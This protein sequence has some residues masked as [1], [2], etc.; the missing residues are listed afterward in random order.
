MSN[1]LPPLAVPMPRKRKPSTASNFSLPPLSSWCGGERALSS[2]SS[3]PPRSSSPPITP[4]SSRGN[5]L[6]YIRSSPAFGSEIGHHAASDL[7]DEFPSTW[8]RHHIHAVAKQP[9]APIFLP[10]FK[11]LFCDPAPETQST[12][13]RGPP[14]PSEHS[15]F[16]SEQRRSASSQPA[17][18]APVF[19]VSEE[20]D[21]EDDS[22]GYSFVQEDV[23][24][25]FFRVSAERGQWK[26]DPLPL[27]TSTRSLLRQSA[28]TSTPP[29]ISGLQLLARPISEPA[30]ST[31]RASTPPTTPDSHEEEDHGSE[32]PSMDY[33]D[34]MSSDHCSPL[35]YNSSR[36]LPSL[37][38]DAASTELDDHAVPSSPLPPSSPPLS[39]LPASPLMRSISPLSFAPSS[40]HLQPS[41]PLSFVESLSP[42]DDQDMDLQNDDEADTVPTP[43]PQ[44]TPSLEN[45]APTSPEVGLPARSTDSP[46][47]TLRPQIVPVP[48]CEATTQDSQAQSTQS[49]SPVLEDAVLAEES[50]PSPVATLSPT[51]DELPISTVSEKDSETE[52]KPLSVLEL[53]GDVGDK[54][55]LGISMEAQT[56]AAAGKGKARDVELEALQPKDEN[57]AVKVK[58]DS[59]REQRR[60]ERVDGTSEGPVRKKSRVTFEEPTSGSSPSKASSA[61][62]KKARK[63]SKR[64]PE[65]DKEEENAENKQAS[66]VPTPRAKK[67]KKAERDPTAKRARQQSS[68][69]ST[70]SKSS[71]SS[72]HR[73]VDDGSISIPPKPSKPKDPETQALDAEITGMLIETMA[74]SRASCLPASTL[75]KNVMQSRP[76]LKAERTEKDWMCVILRVLN[77]GEV[78]T[79]GSGVF[80][81]VESSFKVQDDSDRPLEAQWF[82]VPEL[83]GDQERATLIRS[84]MPRAGKRSE[85]KKYKQYYYR[86]LDKI[87]RW[88]PEDEM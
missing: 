75:Y 5:H 48:A 30:P 88:D 67:Q 31:G 40:P 2:S 79:G 27:K 25:T 38:S 3:S 13:S 77:E 46:R 35:A 80:G 26:Y 41:S 56:S 32:M 76:A 16:F 85:T 63:D 68:T 14:T 29:P 4:H 84:M 22:E 74:T 57:G 51:E 39:S 62:K 42:D 73:P 23:R 36:S 43:H 47:L 1:T 72:K 33:V 70:S 21:L 9:E 6:A 59:K 15:V 20:E 11:S 8:D 64:K 24:S 65:E 12:R 53:F 50:S 60:K 34:S 54:Q 81:K 10:G 82:Y 61:E 83:D 87:S 17:P 66:T 71:S 37:V 55:V 52:I 86:P 45:E 58:S 44:P 78:S 7:I 28:P 49:T 19:C 18:Y 69:T